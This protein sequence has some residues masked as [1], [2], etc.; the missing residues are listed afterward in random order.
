MIAKGL[1]DKDLRDRIVKSQFRSYEY[2]PRL[3]KWLFDKIEVPS[4]DYSLT[5]VPDVPHMVWWVDNFSDVKTTMLPEDIGHE[6]GKVIKTRVGEIPCYDIMRD[7]PIGQ[8][9]ITIGSSGIGDK[10][11]LEIIVLGERAGDR[12]NLKPGDVIF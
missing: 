5:E 4:A 3:A 8:A 1:L 7:V 9:A 12:F 6:V 2:M 11:F 10:R